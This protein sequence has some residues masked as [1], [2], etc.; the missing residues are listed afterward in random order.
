MNTMKAV[1]QICKLKLR[2]IGFDLFKVLHQ[3]MTNLG[4]KLKFDLKIT[5]YLLN[6]TFKVV[7]PRN[8]LK[9]CPLLPLSEG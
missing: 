2:E 3:S 5:F 7:C 4:F 9:N 8:I 1:L 6:L